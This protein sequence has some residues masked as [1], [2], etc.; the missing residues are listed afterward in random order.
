MTDQLNG[1]RD[2]VFQM[3]ERIHFSFRLDGVHSDL[4]LCVRG[5]GSRHQGGE[6]GFIGGGQIRQNLAVQFNAG[7]FQTADELAVGDVRG[8]AGCPDADD[9]ER[10]E[11]ALLAPSSDE[12]VTQR[13]F[14]GFLRRAIQLALGE[15]KARRP[16]ERLF[17][18]SPSLGP[19]FNS[20]HV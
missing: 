11:I 8:A 3:I 5:F 15:K 12:A 4:G 7:L 18:V 9:P 19:S 1:S 13:L 20:W 10:P 6:C 2:A 14:D 16:L 17:T